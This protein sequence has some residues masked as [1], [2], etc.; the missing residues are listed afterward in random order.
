M[1]VILTSLLSWFQSPL[2]DKEKSL[3]TDALSRTQHR[4]PQHQVQVNPNHGWPAH[5]GEY[6]QRFPLLKIEN[7][8]Y[9]HL[10]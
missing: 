1:R 3:S 8:N 6:R 2:L 4:Q 7:E 10:L 5:R 9:P